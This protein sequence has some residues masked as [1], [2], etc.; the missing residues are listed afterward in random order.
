M[1]GREN[2]RDIGVDGRQILKLILEKD[3]EDVDWIHLAE[4]R[5]GRG[6]S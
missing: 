3:C 2:L 6:P 4:D 5:S 1:K